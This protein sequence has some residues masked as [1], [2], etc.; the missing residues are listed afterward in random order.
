M[1]KSAKTWMIRPVAA[2]LIVDEFGFVPFKRVGGEKG[3]RT[4][5]AMTIIMG[6][7]LWGFAVQ[8]FS[9]SM[10]FIPSLSTCFSSAM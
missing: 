1:F 4:C 6:P 3:E 7:T 8:S 5:F 2:L 10:A 9:L